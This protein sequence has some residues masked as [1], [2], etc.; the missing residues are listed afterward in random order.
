M[1]RDAFLSQVRQAAEAGRR[2]RVH[3]EPVASG[4]GYVGAEGDLCNALATEIESIGGLPRVVTDWSAGREW[5][6]LLLGKYQARS[7]LCWEHPALDRLGLAELL[8]QNDIT[9]HGYE[10]LKTLPENERRATFLSAEM[11]I[12]SADWAIAETGTL[13]VCYQPGQERV[14]SLVPPVH[15][16]IVASD[17]IVPDLFDFFSALI[18]RGVK[19]LPSNLALISGPSKTGDIEL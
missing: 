12:S 14:I 11:G 15:V 8:A 17:Q 16:A 4:A 18:A 10:Q 6:R 9:R 2:Y 7:V 1:K 3:A 19:Q 5:I 13:A